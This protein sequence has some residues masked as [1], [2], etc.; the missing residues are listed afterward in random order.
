MLS[1]LIPTYDYNCFPFVHEL[2]NQLLKEKISFEIICFDDG[3]NSISNLENQKINS[4]WKYEL[5][6]S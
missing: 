4:L 5:S 3:S 6:T 1:V 2:H